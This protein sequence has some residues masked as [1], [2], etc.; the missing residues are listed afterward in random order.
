VVVSAARKELAELQRICPS[1]EIQITWDTSQDDRERIKK[2]KVKSLMLNSV[3][4]TLLY[5]LQE[6]GFKV[7]ALLPFL[8]CLN[9]LSLYQNE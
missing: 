6:K 9:I 1:H 5:K 3:S 2:E 7:A 4:R 8:K